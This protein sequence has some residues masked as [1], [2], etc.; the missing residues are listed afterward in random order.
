[1]TVAVDTLQQ[2]GIFLRNDAAGVGAAGHARIADDV[3]QPVG[4][5]GH[6]IFRP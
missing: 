5:G 4:A 2:F 6:A 3:E 1:M